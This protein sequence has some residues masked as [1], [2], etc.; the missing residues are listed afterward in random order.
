MFVLQRR[1]ADYE[2]LVPDEILEELQ[3]LGERLKGAKILHINSTRVGGGVAEILMSLVPLSSDA[4]PETHWEIIEGTPEFFQVT[5]T[6]HNALQGAPAVVTPEMF[7]L[8]QRVNERN[9][10]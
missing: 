2:N 7:E 8:Y 5:K 4:G 9:A 10:Q 1:L 3:Q 6:F